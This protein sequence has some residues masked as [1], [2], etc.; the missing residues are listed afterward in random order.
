MVRSIKV[1]MRSPGKAYYSSC[2]RRRGGGSEK[3]KRKM[4]DPLGYTE[5]RV[6][7]RDTPN[8]GKEFLALVLIPEM[9]NIFI[10]LIKYVCH[11]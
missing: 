5:S 2:W 7:T 9:F 4:D 10:K 6:W 8:T 11:N 3:G 1:F